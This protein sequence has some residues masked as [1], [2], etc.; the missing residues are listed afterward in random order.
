MKLPR[1]NLGTGEANI[2]LNWEFQP[3]SEA[4]QAPTMGGGQLHCIGLTTRTSPP[5]PNQTPQ[6]PLPGT[7][8]ST[9]S[10]FNKNYHCPFCPACSNDCKPLKAVLSSQ[11]L[12]Q[13]SSSALKRVERVR[14]VFMASASRYVKTYSS[15]TLSGG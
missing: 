15:V 14:V 7:P 12:R 10:P 9:W 13:L 5:S 11:G 8:P 1:L 3:G 6:R 2:E 4:C